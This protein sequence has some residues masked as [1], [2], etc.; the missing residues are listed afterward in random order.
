MF[1]STLFIHNNLYFINRIAYTV[2][3]YLPDV[4]TNLFL[5]IAQS[6]IKDFFLSFQFVIN[7]I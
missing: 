3:R 5:N 1:S 7:I 6:I 4:F 2:L